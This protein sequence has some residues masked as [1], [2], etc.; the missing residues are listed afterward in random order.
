MRKLDS[1]THFFLRSGH[2]I[3]HLEMGVSPVYFIIAS[4]GGSGK[5]SSRPRFSTVSA[6][7]AEG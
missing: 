2:I 1:V 7:V 5:C 6:I 3:L 4:R